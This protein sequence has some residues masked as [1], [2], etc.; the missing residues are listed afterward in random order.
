MKKDEIT[1]DLQEKMSTER[2]IR[3]DIIDWEGLK[4][5]DKFSPPPTGRSLFDHIR[6]GI[7]DRIILGYS[8][9]QIAAEITKAGKLQ[10]PVNP[11]SLRTWLVRRKMSCRAMRMKVLK[12]DNGENQ[13]EGE[14][15][16]TEQSNDG[17]KNG[18]DF[19]RWHKS[20]GEGE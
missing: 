14:F 1:T 7:Y 5:F 18:L 6:N 8:V 10:A 16:K 3:V 11:A 4:E 12:P 17:K 19:S 15:P 2:Y 13:N 20:G 9:P